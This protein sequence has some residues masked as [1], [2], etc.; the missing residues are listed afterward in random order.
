MVVIKIKR[1]AKCRTPFVSRRTHAEH[2]DICKSNSENRKAYSENRERALKKLGL[3]CVKCG[4]KRID[5][6]Q[7][8]HINNNGYVERKRLTQNGIYTRV[9][10]YPEDY[11]LLCANCNW[12]KRSEMKM[13]RHETTI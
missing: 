7:I 12:L 4:D 8:D 6:L 3:K 9:F 1:C 13:G 11:Q 2:C 5:V 10:F